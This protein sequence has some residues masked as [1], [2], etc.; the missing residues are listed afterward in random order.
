MTEKDIKLD[1]GQPVVSLSNPLIYEFS[2]LLPAGASDEKIEKYLTDH[3]VMILS[4]SALSAVQLAYPIK[5]NLSANFGFYRVTVKDKSV[6]A[7]IDKEL[8]IKE[9]VIRHLL[10]KVPKK[11]LVEKPKP[12][13]VLAAP[14]KKAAALSST[15][16]LDSLSNEKLEQTLEEILK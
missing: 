15:T 6:L 8:Q 16:Q 3:E 12:A 2:F 5:K 7:T 1:E 11:S 10:V 14:E 4:K 13:P 9:F